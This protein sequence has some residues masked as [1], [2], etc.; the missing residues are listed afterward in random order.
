MGEEE[1]VNKGEKESSVFNSTHKGLEEKNVSGNDDI[2]V[3]TRLKKLTQMKNRICENGKR[4]KGLIFAAMIPLRREQQA[5]K[6]NDHRTI[7]LISNT[8]KI[9]TRVLTE[10]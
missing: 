1:L 8:G 4:P 5:K 3:E 7:S 6:Y 9:L 10:D 2:P